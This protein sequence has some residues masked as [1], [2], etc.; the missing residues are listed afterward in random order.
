MITILL[1]NF[2]LILV[3][4]LFSILPV[5]SVASI[6]FIGVYISSFFSTAVSIWNTFLVTFPY[7]VIV[8]HTFLYVII[9]FEI[10]FLVGKFFLGHRM[11]SNS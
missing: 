9:P 7:S 10:L 6:P 11:P 4:F 5:V 3:G 1:I 8:W 2:V